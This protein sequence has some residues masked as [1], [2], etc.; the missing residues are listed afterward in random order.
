MAV[1]FAFSKLPEVSEEMLGGGSGDRGGE[2]IG[3]GD[4]DV[5][6]IGPL[7]QQYNM[8]FGFL[9]QFSYVGAQV[10]IASFFI[11]YATEI[12]K[13]PYASHTASNLLSYA[14]IAFTVGRFAATALATVFDSAFLMVIYAGI[15][16]ALN[17][18]VVAADDRAGVGVLIALFFFEAP[19]YPTLFTLGTANL[20]RHTRRGAG[21][22]V[23]A[24]SGGAGEF[25][26]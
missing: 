5:D 25:I 14:L 8:I 4:G 15:A 6:D 13:N 19:M 16:I 12:S 1:M 2:E 3:S 17:A 24:V 11:N 21:I 22:L 7:S 20:G 10:T 9:A 26:L 18:G 23:M